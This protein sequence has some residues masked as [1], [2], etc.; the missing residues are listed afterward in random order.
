MGEAQLSTEQRESVSAVR[1]VQRVAKAVGARLTQS[2]IDDL[3]KNVDA[4]TKVDESG[5]GDSSRQHPFAFTV[6]DIEAMQPRVKF[7]DILNK[8]EGMVLA[9]QLKKKSEGASEGGVKS[10]TSARACARGAG[11][12]GPMQL[13]LPLFACRCPAL[14]TS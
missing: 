1:A 2:C 14:T 4:E 9:S 11:G 13:P 7:L 6:A 10:A 5:E 12:A 8:S 3:E